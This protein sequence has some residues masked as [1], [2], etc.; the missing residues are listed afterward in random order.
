MSIYI[1][2]TAWFVQKSVAETLS[3]STFRVV[4][5][6][7]EAVFPNIASEFGHFCLDISRSVH[8]VTLPI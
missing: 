7:D 5:G 8:Y 4:V 1:A 3:Y 2:I 6:F